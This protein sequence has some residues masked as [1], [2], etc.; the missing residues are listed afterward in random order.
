MGVVSVLTCMQDVV[1][2]RPLETTG[3]MTVT[4]F[5]PNPR[6]SDTGEGLGLDEARIQELGF[7]DV[8]ENDLKVRP[9]ILQFVERCGQ[10]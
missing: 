10:F 2:D 8:G 6:L 1:I 5:S 9:L 4:T 7:T 3:V